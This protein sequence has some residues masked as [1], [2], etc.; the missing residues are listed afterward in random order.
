MAVV[1]ER[2]NSDNLAAREKLIEYYF[3]ETIRLRTAAPEE[4]REKH[5]GDQLQGWMT[6]IKAG[7][8]PKFGGNLLV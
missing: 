5:V 7:G 1:C 2:D 3:L 6:T 8:V 4:K